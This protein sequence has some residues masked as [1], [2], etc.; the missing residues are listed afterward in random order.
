[1]SE[2]YPNPDDCEHRTI[3][4]TEHDEAPSGAEICKDCGAL[5]E[6]P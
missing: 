6:R 1:M 2:S 5:V 4:A 3:T